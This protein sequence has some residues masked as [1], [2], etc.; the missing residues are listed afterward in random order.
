MI[1]W[2]FLGEINT[3]SV[4]YYHYFER[5]LFIGKVLSAVFLQTK[6][7]MNTAVSKSHIMDWIQVTKESLSNLDSIGVRW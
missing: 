3:L 7:K 4:Y 2:Y 5:L 1:C 6:H